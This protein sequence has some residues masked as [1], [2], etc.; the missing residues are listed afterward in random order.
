SVDEEP[1]TRT[2]QKRLAGWLTEFIHGPEGLATATKA[3]D[4]FFGAEIADLND[5]QLTEIFH[6]VPSTTIE[7]GELA[8]GLP[9]LDALL[10]VGLAKSKS[11]ARRTVEQGGG[12]VNNRRV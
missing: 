10:R 7:R 12:S 6:D 11:D 3:T 5:A 8:S 4:V 1:H 9:L 2:A